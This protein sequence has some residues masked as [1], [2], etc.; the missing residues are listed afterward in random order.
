MKTKPVEFAIPAGFTAPEG[1]EPGEDFDVVCSLRM[2]G[3]GTLCL[4]KLGDVEM[5]GYQGRED[6]DERPRYG[7]ARDMMTGGQP[8]D[9]QPET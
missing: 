8:M 1:T 2:K 7:M 9:N 3:N 4:T 5:P 6:K